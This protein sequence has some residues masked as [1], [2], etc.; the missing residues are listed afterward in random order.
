[1]QGHVEHKIMFWSSEYQRWIGLGGGG[2]KYD[3][4]I[5]RQQV[6]HESLEVTGILG[7]GEI[8]PLLSK[9]VRIKHQSL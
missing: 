8:S 9:F 2:F 5:A 1:M 3:V 4:S 7:R 6:G